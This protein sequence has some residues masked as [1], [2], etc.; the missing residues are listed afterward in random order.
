MEVLKKGDPTRGK[1]P[2]FAWTENCS[3]GSVLKVTGSDVRGAS[4][5]IRG[6]KR[7]SPGAYVACPTCQNQIRVEPWK[8]AEV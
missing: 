4:I 8:Y 6:R 1:K 7:A 3:C 2:S 5:D